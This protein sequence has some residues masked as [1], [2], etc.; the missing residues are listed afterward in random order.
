MVHRVNSI[1]ISG[2]ATKDLESVKKL[3]RKG[4]IIHCALGGKCRKANEGE[5]KLKATA[6]MR[7]YSSK[8]PYLSNMS[9]LEIFSGTPVGLS[10]VRPQRMKTS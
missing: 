4:A 3:E 2:V 8:T 9:F 1:G 5:P 6:L 7:S 10:T